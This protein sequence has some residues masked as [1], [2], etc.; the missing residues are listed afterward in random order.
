M[1]KA[2]QSLLDDIPLELAVAIAPKLAVIGFILGLGGYSAV[3]LH[4]RST[5][6]KVPPLLEWIGICVALSLFTALIWGSLGTIIAL[7]GVPLLIVL[8]SFVE[9]ILGWLLSFILTLRYTTLA[10]S[11]LL[12]VLSV[13]A[14]YFWL[15]SRKNQ[16][17]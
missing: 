6:E 12:I 8:V 11:G 7:M 5:D 13:L 16:Q 1:D 4:V 17:R 15:E 2:L 9:T 10:V 14:G 3:W